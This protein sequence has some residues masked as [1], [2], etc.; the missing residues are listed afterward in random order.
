MV[1]V[2]CLVVQVVGIWWG[3]KDGFTEMSK[4]VEESPDL[5]YKTSDGSARP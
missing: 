2:G 5:S 1:V 3:T 4:A